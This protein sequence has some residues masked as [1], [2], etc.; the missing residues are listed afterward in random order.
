MSEP[1]IHTETL[2]FEPDPMELPP[3]R[4]P[5]L[6]DNM[7]EHA[8]EAKNTNITGPIC[9]PEYLLDVINN[10]LNPGPPPDVKTIGQPLYYDNERGGGA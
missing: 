1:Q 2:V 5:S 8:L 4:A 10:L 6:L 7:M 9:L 3:S